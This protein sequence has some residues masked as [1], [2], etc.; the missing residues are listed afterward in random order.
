MRCR[1]LG[2][3]ESRE[4]TTS[5]SQSC[6]LRSSFPRGGDRGGGSLF[7]Q[8]GSEGTH[9]K[10][11][12]VGW[13]TLNSLIQL[14]REEPAPSRVQA[15]KRRSSS[16]EG[17][18]GRRGQW[19]ERKEC[20]HSLSREEQ[21][22]RRQDPCREGGG[23]VRA[24]D[25]GGH[26]VPVW[27]VQQGTHSWVGEPCTE[28]SGTGSTWGNQESLPAQLVKNQDQP[29]RHW[30]LRRGLCSQLGSQR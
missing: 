5:D 20:P 2:P 21:R 30:A 22:G 28:T 25:M 10:A 17:P 14:L 9:I 26:I 29:E 18:S 27:S 24:G 15:G 23:E 4:G 7:T 6:G 11:P 12:G 8:Q 19:P 16:G 1:F 13:C 3:Q